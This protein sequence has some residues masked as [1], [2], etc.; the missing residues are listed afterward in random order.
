MKDG[1]RIHKMRTGYP[2]GY[3][4]ESRSPIGHRRQ[5]VPE[6]KE[7]KQKPR[8]SQDTGGGKIT[9]LSSRAVAEIDRT[10]VSIVV[11]I[12]CNALFRLAEDDIVELALR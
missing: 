11:Q 9:A 8:I 5:E 3:A 12:C 2:Q 4:R 6:N 7:E 10:A 1:G